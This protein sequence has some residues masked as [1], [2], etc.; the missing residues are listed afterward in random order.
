[1]NEAGGHPTS[2]V[3]PDLGRW[4]TAARIVRLVSVGVVFL[5]VVGLAALSV[6][7]YETLKEHVDTFSVD[8]DAGVSRAEFESFVDR[9]RLLALG[10]AVLVLGLMLARRPVDRVAAEVLDAWWTA[11][12]RLPGRLRECIGGEQPGYVAVLGLV[13][14]AGIALRVASLDVPMRYDEATTYDNY[15]SKPLYVGLANY[16]APNNHLLHTFLAKLSV[17]AFGSGEW[18]VRLPA[19]LAGIAL[20][21][22]TFALTR[23]LYGRIAALLAAALVASSST[24]VE[25]SAN[26]R[27]YTIVALLTLIV[28]IA[29]T[30]VLEH[31]SI[32]AWA[33]VAVAGALGLHAVPI[34]I[35]PLGGILLWLLVSRI[36]EKRPLRA[37]GS[38]LGGCVLATAVLTGILY[39]PVFAASGVRSVTS[40]E[41]VEPRSWSAF[42]EMLPEHGRDTIESWGR[43]LPFVVTALLA[44]AVVASLPLTP[45]ISR[46]SIPPFLAIVAWA[47]PVL[48]LQRVV[49]FTRVWLFL[50]PVALAAAAGFYGW[51]LEKRPLGRLAGIAL[52]GLIVVSASAV[53]YSADS[54]RES[55]ETGALLDAEAV[56]DDL[57]ETVRP[58]DRILATGSDTILE[59]YLEREGIEAAPLLYTDERRARTFV[60]VNVLG[61]QT[62]GDLLEELDGASA[63]LGPPRL[64]SRYP[65]ALVYLVERVAETRARGPEAPREQAS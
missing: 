16:S 7:P 27:G 43:D 54:V 3:S 9:L 18:A 34:M 50:L 28:F 35:Y 48:A 63:G 23:A 60:V 41:F 56:A 46:F 4:V 19:L 49:P 52:T 11:L 1:V 12:R 15:V 62:I 22:A 39:A 38:R 14:V 17:T 2:N 53:V 6:V 32:G 47:L 33:V 10:F 5:F 30:R 57:A 21:P 65:S 45:H 29:A 25:Y 44:V 13:L 61:G 55:R 8:R 42:L 64:L 40:N 26:A 59:Y 37:F 31:E 36:A 24:L 51:L 58:G 20:I